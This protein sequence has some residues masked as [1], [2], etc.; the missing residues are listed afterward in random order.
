MG[1]VRV[2]SGVGQSVRRS[3]GLCVPVGLLALYACMDHV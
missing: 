3:I 2:L 1:S